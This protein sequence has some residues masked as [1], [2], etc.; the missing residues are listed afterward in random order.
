MSDKNLSS[1]H[2]E[3]KTSQYDFHGFS[4]NEE[5][6]PTF[7]RCFEHDS[8]GYNP[9]HDL[10]GNEISE[11]DSHMNGDQNNIRIPLP[12]HA[13]RYCGQMNPECVAQ[14]NICKHWFCNGSF[15]P[16]SA[17]HIVRHM[18][19]SRHKE[20]MLH[21]DSPLEASLLECYNCG[22][23]NVFI[24]GFV[25]A[26][27]DSVVLLLCRNPCAYQHTLRDINCDLSQWEPI[28]TE[29]RFIS[30]LVK[31]PQENDLID[32]RHLS[33]SQMAVVEEH[34]RIDPKAC[35]EDVDSKEIEESISPT[36]VKYADPREYMDIYA[37]LI[38]LE[39]EYDKRLKESQAQNNVTFRTEQTLNK[40]KII[41]FTLPQTDSEMRLMQGD[42][43]KL[44]QTREKKTLTIKGNVVKIPNSSF[45]FFYLD[46]GE[47]VGVELKH[48]SSFPDYN[49]NWT[50]E[51]VWKA[52][53][54]D[55]MKSALKSF[56]NNDSDMSEYIRAKLLGQPFEEEHIKLIL[57]KRFIFMYLK[58][59]FSAPGLPE[60]NHSQVYAVKMAL[61]KPLSLIQGPPGTGKTVTSATLVYHIIKQCG[62]QVL[63]SAPSNIAVDQL[64]DKISRTGLKV[65]R[66]CAKSREAIES[67][68]SHLALHNQL[69]YIECIPEL[70]SLRK[71]KQDQ[72]ELT[73]DD[74]KR[75][76]Q[77]RTTIENELL[78]NADVVCTTCIGGGDPRIR[79]IK[80]RC[81]L[82][83]ES[84][85]A[86]E[87]ECMVPVVLGIRQLILVGDHC[88]LGPVV[89]CKKAS[90]A[91]LSRSLF[92]RLIELGIKPFR[93]Q[94]QYRMHPALSEFSSN[95]FYEGTLQ[96]GVTLKD[97][98]LV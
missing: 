57:P 53:T 73:E 52:I 3:Q 32:V 50:V 58:A 81:V 2:E 48:H 16:S 42:D 8:S 35:Y 87:P 78:S 94:V 88:Q 13:C 89:M 64:A 86:T 23:K 98:I 82:L 62:G 70:T 85:Q 6:V 31:I 72:G 92:E 26:K 36:R 14:C 96:N 27:T 84:T 40:K 67:P 74:A 60:L 93:L 25:P 97:L 66:V 54:F 24:L 63:V 51:F 29:K 68:V 33:S 19:K 22:C 43:V 75:Y 91:G 4:L 55:R 34:L 41:Y 21:K 39:A 15:D 59:R 47:E 17:S 56:I 61:Q 49:N 79:G 95:A 38:N 18:V 44:T 69:K 46:Y 65:V 45:Y 83:D 77:L 10:I 80:F 37:P 11:F 12:E 90:G 28:I 7:S 76:A 5:Y 30:W 20:I 71:L 9:G 1:A